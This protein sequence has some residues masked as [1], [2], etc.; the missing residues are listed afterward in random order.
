MATLKKASV[1]SFESSPS[2]LART[3]LFYKLLPPTFFRALKAASRTALSGL[4]LSIYLSFAVSIPFYPPNSYLI[5]Y[6]LNLLFLSS[7]VAASYGEMIPYSAL[8]KFLM[9]S[10]EFGSFKS[11]RRF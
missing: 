8:A 6:L 11:Y 3:Y 2:I 7:K 1:V 5:N 10:V 9:I 4:S